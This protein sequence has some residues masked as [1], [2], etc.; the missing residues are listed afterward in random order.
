[1]WV[2]KHYLW[3]ASVWP[4]C[5]SLVFSGTIICCNL[6][7]YMRQ[8]ST[9]TWCFESCTHKDA[10]WII[11]VICP[12]INFVHVGTSTWHFNIISVQVG[13]STWNFNII[14]GFFK[15]YDTSEIRTR[16]LQ[17]TYTRRVSTI[18]ASHFFVINKTK[19]YCHALNLC[20]LF[21]KLM[22]I[23]IQMIINIVQ[24]NLKLRLPS[25]NNLL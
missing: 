15:K 5:L 3:G 20:K 10:D 12:V 22:P 19:Q 6:Y 23:Q 14:S 18:R 9:C 8:V 1:M 21:F 24:S 4:T 13:T 25:L 17:P 11:W 7:I 2:S 16:V